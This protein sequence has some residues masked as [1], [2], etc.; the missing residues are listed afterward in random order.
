[1]ETRHSEDIERFLDRLM[2]YGVAQITDAEFKR[3]Y[4][5]SRIGHRLKQNFE[6]K[7]LERIEAEY[8]DPEN[9]TVHI[10]SR[11]GTWTF[12]LNDDEAK[13]QALSSWAGSD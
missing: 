2:D 3:Y 7:I 4:G 1:M 11:G 9:C 13:I 12:T 8:E 10:Y 5:I 6:N